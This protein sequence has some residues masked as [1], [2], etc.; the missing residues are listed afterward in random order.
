MGKTTGKYVVEDGKIVNPIKNMRRGD[1]LDAYGTF[2]HETQ[3]AHLNYVTTV[4]EIT[5]L[6]R[7]EWICSPETDKEHREKI[8]TLIEI[9]CQAFEELQEIYANSMDLLWIQE[10]QGIEQARMFY[11]RK[12]EGYRIY[13]QKFNKAAE[14]CVTT[15]EKRRF[16]HN[17]C[18]KASEPLCNNEEYS[19]MLAE[20]ERL[21]EY[22]NNEGSM[23]K[24]L[25]EILD[26][27]ESVRKKGRKTDK[28]GVWNLIPSLVDRQILKYSGGMIGIGRKIA[29]S[30][31]ED[32]LE[33]LIQNK[34]QDMI[35]KKTCAFDFQ[36]V[37]DGMKIVHEKWNAHYCC[38]LKK[39]SRLLCPEKDYM[40][41]GWN[42]AGHYIGQEITPDEVENVVTH[43]KAVVVDFDEFNLHKMC[44][45]YVGVQDTP[46]FVLVTEYHQCESV[47]EELYKGEMYCADLFPEK[48]ENFYTILFFRKRTEPN[49]IFIFPTIKVLAKRLIGRLSLK[50][51]VMLSEEESSLKLFSAFN[52]EVRMLSAITWLLS[53]VS[54]TAWDG[55]T[56]QNAAIMLGSGFG[57]TLMDSAFKFRCKDYWKYRAALPGMDTVSDGLFALMKFDGRENTGVICSVKENGK[58]YP[59]FFRSRDSA[60]EYIKQMT[61]QTGFKVTAIDD[62]YWAVWKER[63]E[64]IYGKCCL[65]LGG[66]RGILI[67]FGVLG[68]EVFPSSPLQK[69]LLDKL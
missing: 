9:L 40:L 63:L 19:R 66:G 35:I 6:L 58:S 12:S 46:V 43:S 5:E 27:N 67:E 32:E 23:V 26:G 30:M 48:V 11:K 52:D 8:K 4:G 51:R 61:P 34:Y 47:V 33:K 38:I 15:E 44:P 64:Q 21:K 49:T 42:D 10:Q 56:M 1:V 65:Y 22:Y 54:G 55:R 3:H 24:R 36:I 20:P 13:S 60:M 41:I 37:L 45:R 16:V 28:A 50:E 2:I 69:V 31:R 18:I 7:Y 68:E 39:Y 59:V 57:K 25:E 62:F 17:I 14:K 53:F 29:E